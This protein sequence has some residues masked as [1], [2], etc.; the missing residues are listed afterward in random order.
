LV[1]ERERSLSKTQDFQAIASQE[2]Q[3]VKELGGPTS[4]AAASAAVRPAQ[5]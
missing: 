4:E 3:L 5:W 2:T 1:I